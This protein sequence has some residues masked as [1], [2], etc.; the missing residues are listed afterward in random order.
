[1]TKEIWTIGIV[2][3]KSLIYFKWQLS[4]LYQQNAPE[5]F[6][7]IIVDNSIPSEL[8]ELKK[9]VEEYVSKYNNISIISHIP[10]AINDFKIAEYD[11]HG[12]ALN[13]I[14]DLVE[15]KYFLVHD[16][17]F[18]WLKK[19]Y[20][21]FLLK[22]LKKGNLAIGSPYPLK[23]AIGKSDFPAC[24]GCA[25]KTSEIK[26]I[27]F[28]GEYLDKELI[29]EY[30]TKYPSSKGWGYSLDVGYRI[31]EQLS[32]KPYISFSQ[33]T[34]GFY[35]QLLGFYTD[36]GVVPVEYFFNKQ[37]IG[38][39]MFGGSRT[40]SQVAGIADLSIEEQ[41]RIFK[42]WINARNCYG[43]YFYEY[44]T[45]STLRRVVEDIKTIML[46]YN[47]L[48]TLNPIRAIIKRCKRS[49]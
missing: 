19:D 46:R 1:M 22:Y 33:K 29:K 43:Q 23:V 37:K 6:K 4:I 17:D 26:N 38:V 2:N 30:N 49:L 10:T 9:L 47:R 14:R 3:Y 28:M 21:N 7:V 11:Q 48:L 41:N 45:Y 32:S 16:P 40:P 20:L 35:L 39:H 25:F 12:E 44:T 34:A 13:I 36:G 5:T 27:N 15:T 31:R 8:I 18:F 42:D 24:F